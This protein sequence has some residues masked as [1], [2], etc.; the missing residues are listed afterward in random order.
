MGRRLSVIANENEAQYIWKRCHPYNGNLYEYVKYENNFTKSLSFHSHRINDLHRCIVK[1]RSI[2][3]LNINLYG[4]NKYK[5]KLLYNY[6]WRKY[7]I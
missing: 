5:P 2:N 7:G 4:L 1:S 3:N 6:M